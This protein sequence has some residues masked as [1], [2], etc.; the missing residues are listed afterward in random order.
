MARMGALL[1]ENE[2]L[3]AAAVI[4][5][6]A[7]LGGDGFRQRD[8][9][10]FL[11]GDAALHVQLAFYEAVGAWGADYGEHGFDGVQVQIGFD[12]GGQATFELP[13]NGDGTGFL[14]LVTGGGELIDSIT[15]VTNADGNFAS[16][17]N[18]FLDDISGNWG[19]V[20]EP[21]TGLLGMIGLILLIIGAIGLVLSLIFWSSWAGWGTRRTTREE[22]VLY[23]DRL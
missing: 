23:D 15:F 13:P 1:L 16:G 2:A 11:E 22:R 6:Q 4:A 5:A 20:P 21:G 19:V 3:A 10:F 14:G 18:V 9:R 17:H 12:G 8:V 7:T